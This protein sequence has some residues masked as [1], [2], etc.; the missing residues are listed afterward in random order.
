LQNNIILKFLI[1]SSWLIF[2]L[3]LLGEYSFAQKKQGM[4][5]LFDPGEELSLQEKVRG[6]FGYT[7]IG[8]EYYD[9]QQSSNKFLYFLSNESLVFYNGNDWDVVNLPGNEKIHAFGL[10]DKGRIYLSGKNRL[11]YLEP[12]LYGKFL[13]RSLSGGIE[14]DLF[15]NNQVK[16][17]ITVNEDV[18]FLASKYLLKKDK[19]GQVLFFPSQS[20]LLDIGVLNNQ[21][22]CLKENGI[23]S[24]FVDGKLID[25]YD[26]SGINILKFAPGEFGIILSNSEE[27]YLLNQ[28]GKVSS[29]NL[30]E[31]LTGIQHSILNA[32]FLKKD[33]IGIS[34]RE[35]GYF[36]INKQGEVLKHYSRSNGLPSNIIF[37]SFL[38]HEENLWLTTSNNIA[39]V[40]LFNPIEQVISED[41]TIGVV[42]S[43]QKANGKLFIATSEGLFESKAPLYQ[44][45]QKIK[46]FSK[47]YKITSQ[48]DHLLL[49]TEEGLYAYFYDGKLKTISETKSWTNFS[50]NFLK[51]VIW[52]ATPGGVEI[53]YK[54]KGQ[55]KNLGLLGDLVD[56]IRDL[57]ENSRGELF[58]AS[59]ENKLYKAH[60][61][62]S[63]DTFLLNTIGL[64]KGVKSPVQSIRMGE[65]ILFGGLNGPFRIEEDELIY[66]SLFI[67]NNA[68]L[69]NDVVKLARDNYG[70]LFVA[71][72]GNLFLYNN[73]LRK[74][75]THSV[76]Q[77]TYSSIF[78]D[79]GNVFFGSD[80]GLLRYN[81][82]F[83]KKLLD[84]F[85]VS[86][87]NVQIGKDSIIYSGLAASV[88]NMPFYEFPA[89]NSSISF[90][91]GTPSYMPFSKI[92]YSYI[93]EG[94]EEEWSDWSE[95]SKVKYGKLGSGN[96]IFKVRSRNLIGTQSDIAVFH[97]VIA[98]PFYRHWSA[99]ILYGFLFIGFTWF[100]VHQNGRRL[101]SI[102][103]KLEKRVYAR[104]MELQTQKER[105]ESQKEEIESQNN[106]INQQLQKLE[107]Q[108]EIIERINSDLTDSIKYARKLQDAIL[109]DEKIVRSIIPQSFILHKP[110]DIVSGDFYYIKKQGDY[111]IFALAD[112]TGHGV[113]GAFMSLVGN[114]TIDKVISQLKTNNPGSLLKELDKQITSIVS[115]EKEMSSMKDGMDIALCVFNFR[116]RILQF[117][118]ALRPLY[119]LRDKK[120]IEIKG[121]RFSIGYSTNEEKDFSTYSSEIIYNDIVYLFSDGVIDQFGG[122]KGKKMMASRFKDILLKYHHL[123]MEAQKIA[124]ENDL[125]LWKGNVEQVDD[126]LLMGF[127]LDF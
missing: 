31:D 102:N 99:F 48:K 19:S 40:D 79:D 7:G 103:E 123:P 57:E 13:F 28:E 23:L 59:R 74:L 49:S 105:T 124:I 5:T 97:F 91:F 41:Q 116:S 35:K 18:Y 10:D 68:I 104:T 22:L 126:I 75:L 96:Y 6:N 90:S 115:K 55:F 86:I 1:R 8:P 16:K 15:D 9:V 73:G 20:N 87:S 42:N 25:L 72:N 113:P 67:R 100:A 38:D 33:I 66:D 34:I 14:K 112:S 83:E 118:S 56:D 82:K 12:N 84:N 53:I 106:Y 29:I 24:E 110:K 63:Q 119:I 39:H 2:S 17:I 62:I 125:R 47:V 127:K 44:Q 37:Q 120:I 3:W 51:D 109:P 52:S 107:K 71:A 98:P 32:K 11:G 26:F 88:V 94:Y 4:I 64:I 81:P 46:P 80:K 92:L 69:E 111:I 108:K 117:S 101:K 45:F 89:D 58:A 114:N 78:V 50:S 70:N 60:L 65:N 61:L 122:P 77:S 76:P 43:I 95:L 54:E 93:L 30:P 85:P 121:N 27:I 21:I 36:I